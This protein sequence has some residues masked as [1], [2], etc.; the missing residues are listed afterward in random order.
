MLAAAVALVMVAG[1]ALAQ[2]PKKMAEENTGP[3]VG[4]KA[5]DFTLKDQD[6]K[7]IKLSDYVKS[8]K[9]AV[10]FYRSASW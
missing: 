1:G 6:G 10:V 4:T 9:T 8:G 2:E 7:E 3:K 5:P